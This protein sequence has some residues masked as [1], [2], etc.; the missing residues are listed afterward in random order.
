M[1]DS[2]WAQ[3]EGELESVILKSSNSIQYPTFDVSENT[4]KPEIWNFYPLDSEKE[5]REEHQLTGFD[6]WAVSWV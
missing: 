4:E 5:L 3:V 6:I 2:N 1:G